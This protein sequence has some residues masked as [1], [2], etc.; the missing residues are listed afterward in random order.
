MQTKPP[1]S[2]IHLLSSLPDL[3]QCDHQQQQQRQ[4]RPATEDQ[5]EMQ[6][7]PWQQ[8]RNDS[9]QSDW[10]SSRPPDAAATAAPEECRPEGLRRGFLAGWV[11]TRGA[12][13]PRNQDPWVGFFYL[14]LSKFIKDSDFR[15][16]R[17]RIWS[18]SRRALKLDWKKAHWDL[19]SCNLWKQWFVLLQPLTAIFWSWM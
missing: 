19:C 10:R 5:E 13:N 14:Q 9:T 18:I 17:T 8:H 15:I 7:W 2:C 12:S 3:R 4:P 1:A 16:P 11:L 6:P